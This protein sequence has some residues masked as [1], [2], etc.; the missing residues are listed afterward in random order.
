MRQENL[1][2]FSDYEKINKFNPNYLVYSPLIRDLKHSIQAYASGRVLD[3]GC[4]NK[5]YERMF[6]GRITEYIGCDII[7]SDKNKVDIICEANNIPVDTNSFD[8]V[9]S[10]QTIEHVADHRGLVSEAFRALKPGGHFIVSGPLYWPLHEEP[11]DFFRFTKYGFTHLMNTTGFSIVEIIPNGG[12]WATTGQSMIHSF[13][14]SRSKNFFVRITRFMFYQL[15]LI[16]TINSFYGWLDRVD[17]NPV[18]TLNYVVVA[19]K[20]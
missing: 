2:R 9:F 11:Y 12:M 17:Q 19:K 13:M 3:I 14:N 20:P 5:P 16:W 6:S 8:T 10:T 15:R 18:N 1:P 4:G 7:Q